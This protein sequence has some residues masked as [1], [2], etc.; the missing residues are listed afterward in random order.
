MDSMPSMAIP[1]SA[2]DTLWD[3]SDASG[4]EARLR[5]AAETET[6]AA[7]RAALETQVARALGLQERY[8]DAD[9][10]L[11]AIDADAPE[12][13]VRV[14]LERGR[15][16]NSSGDA[17][18]ALPLFLAAAEAAASAQL[19]FL[20]VDALHM[21]AIADAAHS[22]RWTEEAFAVL[23]RVADPRTLRW[24]VGLHNNRGWALFDDGRL[25]DAIAEFEQAK[26]A[27][28]R[29]GTPQQVTWADEA[30]AEARASL[31]P[32]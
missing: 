26:D 9:A 25:E 1:Q 3:F 21:L 12:V 24:R 19:D 23:E 29:W 28:I 6:D 31:H 30:L 11:D 8:T 32:Q 5:T 10:V 13:I 2:L 20:R 7:A 18:A 16:R 27:A 4:S 17:E 14:V 22:A 15:L